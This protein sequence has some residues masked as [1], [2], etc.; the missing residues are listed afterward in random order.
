V[1]RRLAAAARCRVATFGL[2]EGAGLAALERMEGE[3]GQ[4]FVAVRDGR[5]LAEVRLALPGPHNAK[6]ALA[7]LLAA[8]AAGQPIEEAVRHLAAWVPPRRRLE[9]TGRGG[10]VVAYDDFAHHPTA[11][12]HTLATLRARVPAGGRLVACFE[13]RSNTMVR[14]VF[15]RALGDAL[16]AADAV[17]LGAIDRPERFLDQERLDVAAVV[18]QL[19][20]RGREAA[21]PLHPDAIFAG[22]TGALAPG[23]VVVVMS[24]GAFGGLARRLGDAV[25][26]RGAV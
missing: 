9:V 1:A 8:E 15:E 7:A 10:G 14:K 13:P 11:I 21:G 3:D 19:R 6:N 23:D 17:F 25:A 4:R 16:S 20:A 26:A 22:V 12:A 18:A 2:D 5:V 24:N